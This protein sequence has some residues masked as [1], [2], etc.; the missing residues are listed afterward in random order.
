MREG[1][2]IAVARELG[3]KGG[4][5]SAVSIAEFPLKRRG[6]NEAAALQQRK[7]W[8][9]GLRAVA[10]EVGRWVDLKIK[11]GKRGWREGLVEV[12]GGG[13]F[14]EAGASDAIHFGEVAHEE[15]GAVGGGD[16]GGNEGLGG[17]VGELGGEEIAGLGE[18]R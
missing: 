9:A 15:G 1:W 3:E 16:G 11:G 18:E 12:A 8:F 6:H 5:E 7:E 4:I 13:E 10:E 2:S 14:G 17:E